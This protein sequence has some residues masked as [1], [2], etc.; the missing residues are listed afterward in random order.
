MYLDIYSM[1]FIYNIEV[2]LKNS[3]SM[4]Y[5][6]I[7]I[8]IHFSLKLISDQSLSERVAN[9]LCHYLCSLEKKNF[10]MMKSLRG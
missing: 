5:P 2:Q 9:L 8:L 6:V 3:S 10:A 4:L 1:V 7:G